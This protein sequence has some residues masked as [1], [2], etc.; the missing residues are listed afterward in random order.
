MPF[1]DL[2]ADG[3]AVEEHT[4]SR[5]RRGIVIG[6]SF[7]KAMFS[8]L[9]AMQGDGAIQEWAGRTRRVDLYLRYYLF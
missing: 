1:Q 9:E 4:P 8:V 6:L 7:F 3:R 2:R 5:A